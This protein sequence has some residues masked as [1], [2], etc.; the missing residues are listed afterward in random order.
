MDPL[1]L[2]LVLSDFLRSN[3]AR[4]LVDLLRFYILLVCQVVL[5]GCYSVLHLLDGGVWGA[6]CTFGSKS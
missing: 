4:E 3:D 1:L 6:L 5:E 2:L